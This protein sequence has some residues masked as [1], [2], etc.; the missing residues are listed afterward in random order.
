MRRSIYWALLLVPLAFGGPAACGDD[1]GTGGGTGGSVGGG[2]GGGFGTAIPDGG[3]E[4]G[5]VVVLPG[6]GTCYINPCND[7]KIYACGDCLDND[8]DGNVD[9]D[10]LDCLGAC[11]N[12]ESSYDIGLTGQPGTQCR[13]DCYYD[14]ESGRG[15]DWSSECDMLEPVAMCTYQ[16]PPA[17]VI[18]SLD[19]DEVAA[20]HEANCGYCETLTP[21]GCDCF[22]CCELPA[23]SNEYVFIGTRDADGNYTCSFDSLGTTVD[24]KPACAPCTPVPSCAVAC[25]DTDPCQRCIGETAPLPEECTA[26]QL[27][28]GSTP[29]NT[30]TDCASNFCNSF[31]G[32]C[33]EVIY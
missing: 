32:C 16:A 12:N 2:T 4:D 14:S 13:L 1:D 29:C 21:P 28:P 19:C 31:T 25:D 7:G 26:E 17:S 10:D 22:G 20:T 8:G 9:K 33:E 6:G 30:Y 5:G 23:G 3:L 18:G 15:C 11:H 24:G 27:C